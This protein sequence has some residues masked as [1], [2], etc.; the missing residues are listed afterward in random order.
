MVRIRRF[1]SHGSTVSE[2]AVKEAEA[3]LRQ[4]R[5]RGGF[6]IDEESD[7]VLYE[8]DPVLEEHTYAIVPRIAGG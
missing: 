3:I 2:E 8:G 7:A 6:I 5:Q 4:S 1:T